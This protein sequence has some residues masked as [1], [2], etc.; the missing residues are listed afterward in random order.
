MPSDQ[1][2]PSRHQA[3]AVSRSGHSRAGFQSFTSGSLSSSNASGASSSTGGRSTRSAVSRRSTR[4]TLSASTEVRSGRTE[5]SRACGGRVSPSAIDGG[6]GGRGEQQLA[7]LR[8]RRRRRPEV[9]RDQ[10]PAAPQREHPRRL[11]GRRRQRGERRVGELGQRP[12]QARRAVGRSPAA[13]RAV[14]PTAPTSPASTA[15]TSPGPAGRAPPRRPSPS[16][17]TPRSA[18]RRSTRPSSGSGWEVKNWNGVEAAHSSPMNSIGVNGPHR[19]SSAAHASWSS[20]RCSVSRSPRARLP[21]WSWFWLQTT[22][23]QVGM[24][25]VSTG[26]PWSRPRNDDHVPSW[27]NPFSHTFASADSGAKSA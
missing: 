12:P 23:R 14:R 11:V 8:Q 21:I 10:Q 9:H 1:S 4:D 27:K 22:S 5:R 24:C 20:S 2:A 7:G 16:A 25:A 6:R 15:R 17:R 3:A 26:T 18:P 13:A 19:V